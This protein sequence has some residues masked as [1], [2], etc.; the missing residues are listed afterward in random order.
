MWLRL[1][2]KSQVEGTVRRL[3]WSFNPSVAGSNPARPSKGRFG[4]LLA[5]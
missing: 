2:E 3:V 1:G 4:R 5:V